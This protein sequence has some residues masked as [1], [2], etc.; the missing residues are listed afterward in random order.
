M[1]RATA[2]KGD[3]FD[4]ARAHLV[5]RG[6]RPGAPLRMTLR[7]LRV[8]MGATQ[9]TI[10]ARTQST[11]GD[12][13]RIEQRSSLDDSALSTLRRYVEAL[14]AE[15]ELA[16]TFPKTGHRILLTGAVASDDGGAERSIARKA[17]RSSSRGN[18]KSRNGGK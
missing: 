14:G 2:T 4:I 9:A 15:L 6:P 10:A 18:R 13:S 1:S 16:V 17:S 11:Q 7:A 8:A 12:I 3:V 5:R